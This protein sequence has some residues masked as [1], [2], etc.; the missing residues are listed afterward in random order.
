MYVA[1]AGSKKLLPF[2]CTFLTVIDSHLSNLRLKSRWNFHGFH[3]GS[4]QFLSQSR[5]WLTSHLW[6]E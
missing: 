2:L 3:A 6:E 1:K 4:V 5:G